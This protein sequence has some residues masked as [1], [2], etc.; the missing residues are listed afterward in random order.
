MKDE[1]WRKGG[2]PYLD[3]LPHVQARHEVPGLEFGH[4]V[5]WEGEALARLR[6]SR[7]LVLRTQLCRSK[8]HAATAVNPEGSNTSLPKV[9]G[10]ASGSDGAS[11]SY[12][13]FASSGH[14][15]EMS[16]LQSKASALPPPFTDSP[17]E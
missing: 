3:A 8:I 7:R 14:G 6:P 12:A 1:R 11:P 10:S 17:A 9:R 2:T 15:S 16:K 13:L 4:L 5:P